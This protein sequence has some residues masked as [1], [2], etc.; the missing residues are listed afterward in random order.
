VSRELFNVYRRPWRRFRGRIPLENR[1]NYLFTETSRFPSII[2]F[3]EPPSTTC[4][5]N[6]RVRPSSHPEQSEWESTFVRLACNGRVALNKSGVDHRSKSQGSLGRCII[7]SISNV[8]FFFPSSLDITGFTSHAR[9]SN[10]G[11]PGVNIINASDAQRDTGAAVNLA[12]L[13]SISRSWRG[14]H[15]GVVESFFSFRL[16]FPP[17]PTRGGGR[18]ARR[19]GESG[20][21]AR[22]IGMYALYRRDR[23]TEPRL[24]KSEG[25]V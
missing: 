1:R 12:F 22:S 11:S 7:V 10:P 25:C 6:R 24:R 15:T 8:A 17:S 23:S 2:R 4:P 18:K 20:G 16:F 5:F 19:R 13:S 9:G 14:D 21:A 3:Q